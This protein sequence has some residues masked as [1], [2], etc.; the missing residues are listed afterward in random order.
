MIK[1]SYKIKAVKNGKIVRE[2]EKI[3]N[4]VVSNTGHGLNLI[5][6]RLIGLKDFDLEITQAKIGKGTTAPT[7][8]DTDLGDTILDGILRATQSQNNNI[9]IIEF[10]I[11]DL[12]LADDTYTEFGLF[13]GNQLFARS[14]ITPSFTKS[15][16][17]DLIVEYTFELDSGEIT[18]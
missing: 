2:S 18:S 6:Q 5:A 9:V 11:A 1:G 16:G 15:T 8:N 12:D 7:L 10:F 17:E 3:D 14:L 13:C 4:L